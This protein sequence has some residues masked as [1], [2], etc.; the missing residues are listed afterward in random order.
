MLLADAFALALA[1]EGHADPRCNLA[2]V[3]RTKLLQPLCGGLL[4]ARG[5]KQLSID[6]RYSDPRFVS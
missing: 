2:D 6:V 4:C 5:E 1:G 3:S